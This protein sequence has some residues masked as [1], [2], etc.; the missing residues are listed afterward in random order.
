MRVCTCGQRN[1][2]TKVMRPV[3]GYLFFIQ[4]LFTKDSN[5]VLQNIVLPIFYIA[6]NKHL[7]NTKLYSV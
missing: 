1:L 2:K 6:Q 5:K 4:E 3:K 7:K